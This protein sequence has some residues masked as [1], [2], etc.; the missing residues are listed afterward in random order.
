MNAADLYELRGVKR[1]VG[2]RAILDIECLSIA[3]GALTSV[4]GPNGAGKSTL[5]KL[6]A[7]LEAPDEGEIFFRGEAVCA[8][9]F[10]NLRRSVTMVDQS[11]FLFRGTVFKNVAYGLMV[12]GMD[13]EEWGYRIREALSL[14]D[15]AGFEDRSVRGLSGGETQR[16]AIAR[17]LVFK[18][19]VILL[20]EPTAGVDTARVEMVEALIKDVNERSEASVIFS[21][22]NIAQ[23]HRL[24]DNVIHMSAGK[25]TQQSIENVFSGCVESEDG[26]RFVRLRGGVRV[27]I[28]EE[29]TGTVRFSI[30][31]S[32]IDIEPASDGGDAINRLDGT[33]TRMEIRGDKVRI[34]IDGAISLRVELEYAQLKGKNI[35]LGSRVAARI[36]PGDM[37]MLE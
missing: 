29:R 30:P 23:A 34:R 25:T 5:L 4:V 32:C 37:R 11:P 14:V 1:T 20:D 18:P 24:T 31:S 15:L 16:V 7:F 35:T 2:G 33:V 12:R 36:P 13:R 17:A 21:T 27:A 28:P 3:E 8:K 9:D 22:H 26:A 19:D 6:M 10:Y